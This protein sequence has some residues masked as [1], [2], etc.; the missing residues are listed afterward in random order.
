[1]YEELEI[2]VV[3]MS[4]VLQAAK[5]IRYDPEYFQYQHLVDADIVRQK[6]HAFELP[7]N[8]GIRVGASAFYPSI[9]QF[10]DTGDIPFYRVGDVDG[11]VD[12]KSAIRIPAKIC[13]EFPTLKMV[14]P[15]DILFTK[16][17]AV[18]RTGYVTNSGAASRDLIFLNT[19]SLPA[20]QRLLLFTYFRTAFFRRMLLRSSS[21]TA[22]PHLTITLV[23]DLPF[24]CGSPQLAETVAAAIKTAFQYSDSAAEKIVECED[25]LLAPLQLQHWETN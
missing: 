13:N 25:N 3:P 16:G 1:M 11:I 7:R 23:R 2:S 5:T 10:Y 18:D 19:S 21:R 20:P 9:E 6:S 17:G 12:V 22:Q 4:A 24:F 14:A 15:G 8:L